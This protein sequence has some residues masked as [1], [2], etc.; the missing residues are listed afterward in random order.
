MEN[1]ESSPTEDSNSVDRTENASPVL[2]PTPSVRSRQ[3]ERQ[4]D[5]TR[6]ALKQEHGRAMAYEG[7]MHQ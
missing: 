5:K 7:A 1:V 4:S 2:T 6:R 3:S